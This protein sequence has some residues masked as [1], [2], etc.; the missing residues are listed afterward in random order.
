M[1]TLPSQYAIYAGS[2]VQVRALSV[3]IPPRQ[4]GSIYFDL[5]FAVTLVNYLLCNSTFAYKLL[6]IT[7]FAQGFAKVVVLGEVNNLHICFTDVIIIHQVTGALFLW[8]I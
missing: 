7:D 5:Y 2:I 6:F 1:Y 3:C 8:M 4:V